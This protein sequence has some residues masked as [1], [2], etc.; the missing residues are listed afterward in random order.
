MRALLAQ[1]AKNSGIADP[2]ELESRIRDLPQSTSGLM[3]ELLDNATNLPEEAFLKAVCAEAGMSWAEAEKIPDGEDAIEVKRI[4]RPQ[5]ALRHRILPLGLEDGESGK[6]ALRLAL[7][8]PF[9]LQTRRAAAAAIDC[10][11]RWCM[12]SRK[13]IH[14]ALQSLYGVGADT[15]EQILANRDFAD[16]EL[17]MRE[18]TN[19][20]DDEDE[21]ASVLN[22]VN[23][24]L[25][26]AL[27]QRATDIH[28]EPQRGH[29]RIRYRIDGILQDVPVPE[30]IV[31]LQSSVLTRLKVMARLDI[32]EKRLP[33]DGRMQ[34]ELD[35]QEID[36]RV[37]CIPAIDGE[38]ISLR[39]LGQENFNLEKLDL[40]GEFRDQVNSLLD[41][42]NGIV[43]L[44]GPTGCGK[45]TSLYTFLSELNVP[46]RRIVTIEDPV[47]NK[48]EGVV[49]I[50]V[51]PEIDLT[52]AS[53]LRSILRGDPNIVMVGEI[54]DL[55][56][57]E[58]AIR[59]ALTGHLVFSTLH[60][61]DSIGGIT[62][63]IDMGVEPFLVSA[64]VRAF[65]AQRLVRRLCPSCRAPVDLP[66]AKL[67]SLGFPTNYEGQPHVPSEEG[68]DDC[69][70]TGFH[71]R[72]AIYEMCVLTQPMEELV[73]AGAQRRDLA[74]QARADGHRSMR[75]YGWL[76]VLDGT[77]SLEELVSATAIEG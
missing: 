39:L 71:G 68:C 70:K 62:R 2:A 22:F 6:K 16:D 74:K 50:A 53:G 75:E 77:T 47:E 12:A 43:L 73:T 48:L 44:T 76:K 52:F 14:A 5:L 28:V 72:V 67:E 1:A 37:A 26:E 33:Q 46:G 41:Q 66:A 51:K 45:S 7:Y 58:I 31:Q 49:Q 34:M 64:S 42:P 27:D 59:A 15:F 4:C 40:T 21:E 57:A 56:T 32:A 29:L 35:G 9:D 25:R 69:R 10:P 23:Q 3:D 18:E 61:N 30:H 55:E 38:S 8:D 20:L 24:I 17:D 36:V 63:L 11:I 13:K 65:I 54:R 19:V 60:T